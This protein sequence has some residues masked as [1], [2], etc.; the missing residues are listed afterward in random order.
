MRTV[1]PLTTGANGQYYF[2]GLLPGSYKVR[3]A[4][5]A[6]YA[7]T[8]N[9]VADPNND[10]ANDS[11]INLAAGG[12]AYESG[13]IVLTVGGEPVEA[14]GFAGDTLD[15][16][17]DT[18]GNM[19][20]DFGFRLQSISLSGNVLHDADG[21]TNGN[22]DGTGT[23]VSGALFATLLD[24]SGNVV[25]SVAVA[26]DGTYTFANVS[27]NT[28][29]TVQLSTTDETGQIGSA[30]STGPNLPAGWVNT[31][32]DCCD[33]TGSD[34]TVNGLVAVSVGTTNVTNANFGIE[35]PPTATDVTAPSQTNPG[36]TTQVTV[37]PLV[38]SDP[39]DGT[40]TTIVI[41]TLPNAA[42][43]GI[44][45]YNGSAVTAGQTIPNFDPALLTV[46]PVDGSVTAD[47]T[48]AT[49]DAAGVQSNLATVTMP[50]AALSLSG[51]VLHDA[52]G[53][54]NG[55]VD[56]VGTNVSGVLY[57]TLLDSSGN[58]VASVP[59]AADGTYTFDNVSCEH[60]LHGATEHDRRDG[61]DRQCA[62]H[63]AESAGGLVEHGGR[64]L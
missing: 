7:P 18:D 64:L 38:V 44:L 42:T 56:G 5:G 10:V 16:T 11:N 52:D 15:D 22:V 53:L 49:I 59:V 61:P 47:F 33:N 35:Q 6:G 54:T 62:E 43:Q 41:A 1:A 48:Y 13:I 14:G 12:P 4:P 29:Y 60:G 40:P 51:N 39:E 2:F 19:T 31:G 37:P 28:A 25:A 23:N 21:L 50:F 20:V 46:D 17:R 26:A 34:G 45:Y 30:P 57:A 58:V 36:G 63:G 32:E 27:P 9:Q 3:V 24:S 55:N 8:A